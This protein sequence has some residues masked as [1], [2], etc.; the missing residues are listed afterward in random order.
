M[1]C[2]PVGNYGERQLEILEPQPLKSN[3]SS[4]RYTNLKKDVDPGDTQT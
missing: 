2:H 3:I 1:V 4:R